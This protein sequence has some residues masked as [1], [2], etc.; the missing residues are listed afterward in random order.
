MRS[1]MS[2]PSTIQAAR[3]HL[4]KGV[5]KLKIVSYDRRGKRLASKTVKINKRSHDFVYARSINRTIYAD[6]S[7]E[8]WMLAGK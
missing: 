8:M 3:L 1:W 2:L 6:A 7:R 4:R 5:S